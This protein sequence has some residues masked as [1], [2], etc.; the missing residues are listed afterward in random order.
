[1]QPPDE[2]ALRATALAAVPG[3]SQSPVRIADLL[4]DGIVGVAPDHERTGER[5][6]CGL[7]PRRSFSDRLD[8]DSV[9][10]VV[11]DQAADLGT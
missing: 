3:L 9:T 1:M 7:L 11:L 6:I 2:T 5:S 4:L 10:A 8:A